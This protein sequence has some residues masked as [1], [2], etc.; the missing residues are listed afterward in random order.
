[1]PDSRALALAHL[2]SRVC[3]GP[4][5]RVEENRIDSRLSVATGEEFGRAPW[6]AK[7]RGQAASSPVF[8]VRVNE[9]GG[10]VPRFAFH[11]VV[12]SPAPSLPLS[13]RFTL[14]VSLHE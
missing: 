4:D 7:L 10:P 12:A 13:R 6:P 8:A 1:M 9:P 5:P 11:H 2:L 14:P 3:L